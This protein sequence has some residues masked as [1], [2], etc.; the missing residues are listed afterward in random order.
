MLFLS[1]WAPCHKSQIFY[2]SYISRILKIKVMKKQM[3]ISKAISL[4]GLTVVFSF[5]TIFPLWWAGGNST[6]LPVQSLALTLGA[7]SSVLKLCLNKCD[8]QVFVQPLLKL[9]S[10]V[11]PTSWSALHYFTNKPWLPRSPWPPSSLPMQDQ[12]HSE[13]TFPYFRKQS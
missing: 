13:L 9:Y 2:I 7:L 3:P 8:I 5:N 10:V 6:P 12:W 4:L 11:L 1:Q